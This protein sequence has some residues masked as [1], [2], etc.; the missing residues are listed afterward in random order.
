MVARSGAEVGVH[1]FRASVLQ[2][3]GYLLGVGFAQRL[4]A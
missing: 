3:E 2:D 1:R 4:V